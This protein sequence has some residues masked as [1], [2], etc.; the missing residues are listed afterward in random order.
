MGKC[1]KKN[2]RMRQWYLLL[3]CSLWNMIILHWYFSLLESNAIYGVICTVYRQVR[4][5][6]AHLWLEEGLKTRGSYDRIRSSSSSLCRVS[7]SNSYKAH[8]NCASWKALREL[9]I[10]QYYS[11]SVCYYYLRL[12]QYWL[13]EGCPVSAY[14][15]LLI[16]DKQSGTPRQGVVSDRNSA[17]QRVECST[18]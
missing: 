17:L 11:I 15:S 7:L 4:F 10:P 9:H 16:S 18:N 3:H 12:L 5:I 2:T 14:I 13:L 8:E 1:S 6:Y